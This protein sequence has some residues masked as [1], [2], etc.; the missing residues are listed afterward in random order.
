[1]VLKLQRLSEIPVDE[2]TFLFETE[3]VLSADSSTGSSRNFWQSTTLCVGKRSLGPGALSVV[4]D[5]TKLVWTSSIFAD[6][7]LTLEGVDIAGIAVSSNP[8]RCLS[9]QLMIMMTV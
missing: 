4:K 3:D 7:A 6:W 8:L 2:L 9:K 5:G 1:M